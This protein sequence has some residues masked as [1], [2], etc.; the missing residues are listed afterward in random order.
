MD[1]EM[2]TQL[3]TI[4]FSEERKG[5]DKGEVRQFLAEVAQWVEG[6]GGDVVRRRLERIAHKSANMLADAEDGAEALRREAEQETQAMLGEAK[7][8]ADS[9][10]ASAEADA[11]DQLRD[12]RTEVT[13]SREAANLYASETGAKADEYAKQTRFEAKRDC[14]KLREDSAQESEQT[15]RNAEQ[16]ADQILAEANR[17]REA[18]E[19]IIGDLG[20]E[21]DSVMAQ[22]RKLALELVGTV[23][24]VKAGSG[25]G[26]SAPAQEKVE[27]AKGEDGEDGGTVEELRPAGIVRHGSGPSAV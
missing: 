17:Q 2:L 21:R 22:V 19:T 6:G 5:F 24:S 23:D 3:R 14:D 12:A 16:R 27:P 10:R 9:C 25:A 1:D 20:M 8:E 18:V 15:V 26:G 4:A 13:S 11:R 7:A